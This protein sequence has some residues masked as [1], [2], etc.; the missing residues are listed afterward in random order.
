MRKLKDKQLFE[1]IS[2]FLL[3]YLPRIRNKSDC[4]ITSYRMTLKLFIQFFEQVKKIEVFDLTVSMITRENI[5]EFLEW[6]GKERNCC[7]STRNNR[8]SCLRSFY[9]YL[10]RQHDLTSLVPMM[11]AITE[12]RKERVV[13]GQ[14]PV[15]LA[16]EE[17]TAVLSAPDHNS[18][19]GIRDRFFLTFLYDSG[20]RSDE[21]LSLRL[22]DLTITGKTSKIHIIG[23]GGKSRM[24]PIS[25][26][27]TALMRHYLKTFHPAQ[28]KDQFLFFIERNSIKRKMSSDNAARIMEK[29]EKIVKKDYPDLPHLHPH[30][31]RH[32]RAQNLYSAGM[33]LPLVSEWLGHSQMETTLIYAH[34]DVD[35]KRKAI[36]KATSGVNMLGDREVPKYMKDEDTI[37]IL[38]GIS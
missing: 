8:L 31:F 25:E 22:Q 32:T 20:C 3:V 34:A 6:L 11:E 13:Q 1:T 35:M 33:P 18:R 17:L 7:A 38:Y 15:I 14:V 26:K 24:T 2:S 27:A 10:V 4:T 9:K 21:I 36:E 12:I 5:V 37:K 23:K 29:Y 28:E 16:K 30:L 19:I